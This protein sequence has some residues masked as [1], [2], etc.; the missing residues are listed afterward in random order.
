MRLIPSQM[1]YKE[2]RSKNKPRTVIFWWFLRH[3]RITHTLLLCFHT[4]LTPIHPLTLDTK[5]R[6]MRN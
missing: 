1:V 2:N 5:G 3:Y 4:S 6:V